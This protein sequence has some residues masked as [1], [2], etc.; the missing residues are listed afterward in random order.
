M[1]IFQ[2]FRIFNTWV[3]DPS[4]VVLLEAVIKVIKQQNLMEQVNKTGEH[5]WNGLEELQVLLCCN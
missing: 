3:G 1:L 4:K 2:P 5:L